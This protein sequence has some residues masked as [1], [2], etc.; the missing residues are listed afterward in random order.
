MIFTLGFLLDKDIRMKSILPVVV[1]N[2]LFATS[3]AQLSK[4]IPAFRKIDTS[5]LTMNDCSFA[6]GAPAMHLLKYEEVTLFVFQNST[7]QVVTLTR[8]RIKILKK[9]GFKYASVVIDYGK[10][11]SKI[12]NV[13]GA[14]YNLDEEGKIKATPVDKSDIFEVKTSKKKKTIAFTFP[15]VKEGSVL[16][17]RFTRKDKRS[18]FIP[19]WY[20][21]SSIPNLLSACKINRPYFSMLQKKV[22][23]DWPLDNQFK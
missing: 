10:N 2:F 13:E 18:Y 8:Y 21:Q 7:T 9:S 4:D 3:S 14:T 6:P 19:S 15:Q 1:F 20:F 12:T 22:I 11:E 17:Y 23:G 16:E 5:E